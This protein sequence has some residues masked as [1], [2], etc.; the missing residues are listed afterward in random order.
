MWAAPGLADPVPA[1]EAAEFGARMLR[2]RDAAAADARLA[3][4]QV[5][6]LAAHCARLE[7]DNTALRA[8]LAQPA[9]ST[10]AQDRR[11]AVHLADAL[12][13]AECRPLSARFDEQAVG[14]IQAA[15]RRAVAE[16]FGVELE[17]M[18]C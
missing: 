5:E 1:D 8:R 15:V 2:E 18:S 14:E 9:T 3:R 10:A 4:Q 7:L 13:V 16:H 12:A 11:N 6:K 17:G